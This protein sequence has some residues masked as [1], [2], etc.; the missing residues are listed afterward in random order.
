MIGKSG[1]SDAATAWGGAAIVCLA[2][3]GGWYIH[4]ARAPAPA[5]AAEIMT[6]PSAA[7]QTPQAKP[8]PAPSGPRADVARVLP[9]G[10]VVV[11]GR[12]EAGAKVT[13]LDNGVPLMETQ[14][15]PSSGE[16]VFLPP[17]LPAGDHNLA[18]RGADEGAKPTESAIMAFT[19]AAPAA[20]VANAA[21]PAPESPIALQQQD[22]PESPMIP[23]SIM[24]TITRG[25]TLWRLSRERLGRGA[26]Y[27]KIFQANSDK[28]HDPNRIYPGQTLKLP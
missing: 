18:L 6:A 12:T 3:A 5:P 14:A 8:A 13:L 4:M 26:L 22:R 23:R 27:P 20:K 21:Q 2:L 16:F 19:I 7:P 10:D 25:D 28:I 1:M 17:R 9:N 11:A 15:D 24:A